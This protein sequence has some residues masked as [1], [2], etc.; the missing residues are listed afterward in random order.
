MLP[1]TGVFTAEF[2]P[3]MLQLPFGESF[4]ALPSIPLP[5]L[6]ASPS[7]TSAAVHVSVISIPNTKHFTVYPGCSV[8]VSPEI[9]AQNLPSKESNSYSINHGKLMGTT[10]IGS[11][12]PFIALQSNG[13]AVVTS[14]PAKF[15]NFSIK[16]WLGSAI[17]NSFPLK[18]PEHWILVPPPT[19]SS[20]ISP[21][22]SAA[23]PALP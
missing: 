1:A 7:L 16:K 12:Q 8:A 11:V 10:L 2:V 20:S 19:S 9:N 18:I 15:N 13:L 21:V 23:T 22:V 3:P 6:R 17:P 5:T 14:S 4:S